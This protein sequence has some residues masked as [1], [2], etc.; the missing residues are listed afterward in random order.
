[1]NIFITGGLGF[2]G[3]KLTARLVEKGHRVTVIGRNPSKSPAPP[4]GVI[5]I[6]GDASKP[7]PWQDA[8]A[9]HDAVINL[10]GV[11]IFSRWS[12]VKKDEIY[13]SRIDITRSVA[14]A[15]G[16]KAGKCVDLISASA[17]GYYGFHG[18]EELDESDRPGD[19]FLARVCRDW[20][21]EAMKAEHSGARV[22]IARFG[23]VLGQ[24][25]G[26][27]DLLSRIF[28]YRLGNRLGSGKQWFSWIHAD[29]L[30]A[31]II[32][33]LENRGLHGPVNCTAPSP[34][35]N[36]D[37]TAALNRALGTFP[38]VPPAPGFMIR[39][40]LGEF[41]DFLLKGQRALPRRLM[42]TGFIFNYPEIVGALSEITGKKTGSPL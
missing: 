27:M 12:T 34:L 4:P 26:A 1:M 29:D 10:A 37:F 21:A 9:D 33:L 17:V 35:T 39:M 8:L 31:A 3:M 16:R 24:D 14:E 19:D 20:E 38:L 32:Q 28:R 2:I 23:V 6:R 15:L 30:A 25:G 11:S 13:R 7:G 40:L 5:I 36:R 22:A 41:G 18:D 42:D